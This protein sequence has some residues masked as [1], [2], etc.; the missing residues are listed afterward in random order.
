MVVI[1]Y[2]KLR[3]L[4]GVNHKSGGYIDDPTSIRPPFESHS[5]A[6]LR[7]PTTCFVSCA[8]SLFALRTLRQHGL[9]TEALQAVF[10]AIVVNKLTY[11]S[12]AWWVSPQRMIECVW[13]RSFDDAID[14][15]FVMT[16]LG[17]LTAS[18]VILC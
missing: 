17:R 6:L 4:E 13:R 7:P 3:L 8:Q 12:P 16:L 18:V 9:P 14:S 15:D 10:Q 2:I 5:T 1:R 11:A